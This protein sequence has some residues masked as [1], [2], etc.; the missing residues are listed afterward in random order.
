MRIPRKY[1]RRSVL[2]RTKFPRAPGFGNLSKFTSP[3][4]V[5]KPPSAQS[6]VFRALRAFLKGPKRRF[7]GS[8]YVIDGDTIRIHNE[9]IR[10]HALDAPELGQIAQDSQGDWYDQGEYVSRQ[11]TD[12]IGGK[13]VDVQVMAT[14]K[15]RR[16]VGI[17]KYGGMDVN[18]W[19]VR[20]GYAISAYGKQYKSAERIAPLA[21]RGIWNDK[22]S[23]NPAEWRRRNK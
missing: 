23:Y 20:N 22:V 4:S 7:S 1:R 21:G 14:D 8:A 16:T 2:P 11:L 5:F 17:V 18:D 6:I 19:L 10:L 9:S 3:A 13:H 12:L 15:Y